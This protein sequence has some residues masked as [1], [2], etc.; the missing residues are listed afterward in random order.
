MIYMEGTLQGGLRGH[1]G[2]SCGVGHEDQ[3]GNHPHTL[4]GQYDAIRGALDKATKRRL[5]F[6]KVWQHGPFYIQQDGNILWQH[7]TPKWLFPPFYPLTAESKDFFKNGSKV[8]Y[9]DFL[10][11]SLILCSVL[12][13]FW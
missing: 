12:T 9:L 6:H 7:A 8:F 5:A 11:L 13:S 10:F 1:K 3:A 2:T 4:Q